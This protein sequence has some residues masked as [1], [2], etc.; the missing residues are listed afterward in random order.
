LGRLKRVEQEQILIGRKGV[1]LLYLWEHSKELNRSK[2]LE[3][4]KGKPYF[5]FGKTEKS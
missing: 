3:G 4:G 5:K 2:P 1:A